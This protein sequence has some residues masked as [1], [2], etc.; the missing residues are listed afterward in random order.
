MKKICIAITSRGN[1]GH[2]RPIMEE[3][4]QHPDL[5]LQLMAGGGAVLHDYGKLV[6]DDKIGEF[7]VEKLLY[8][9]VEGENPTTMA[10]STGVA[11]QEFTSA[12]VDLQPDV[13]LAIGDRFEELA[14][15]I[16]TTY[17]NIPLAH[18]AGGEISGSIDESIRHAITKLSHLH[19]PCTDTA[20]RRII[21]MGEPEE[22]VHVVGTPSFDV[23][24][25][26]N[27]KDTSAVME[28][29]NKRG[30]GPVVD[31][32]D[33]YLIVIQHP[34]TTE[35]EENFDYVNETIDAIHELHI[36]TI[37]L[38][39]NMDAGSDGLSQGI[40]TYR[41]NENPDFIHFFVSLP[42]EQFAP[43]LNNAKCIVGNSS[44]GL[45]EAAFLGIPS[46]NIGNR[47]EGRE[48]G[49]N[50]ID[51]P[52]DST[53]IKQAIEKQLDHGPYKPDPLYGDGKTSKRIVDVLNRHEF[54]IQKKLDMEP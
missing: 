35:Y 49:G 10:Q 32:D 28:E 26:L 6:E 16:A 20:A 18:I 9:L 48:R 21:Q 42:I 25:E 23:M 19:F 7:D 30:T 37:W 22:N 33:E 14:L 29:Q 31:L 5:E 34:V 45:R 43:L 40:R 12:F 52:Y 2:Y 38:W 54:D 39:P 41:E 47:Q 51:V 1:Y 24:N 50:V 3:I 8:F 27:L 46:V 17:M 4:K 36:P 11:I 13:V 53:E 44:T 15:A